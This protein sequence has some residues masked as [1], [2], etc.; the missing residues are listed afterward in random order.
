[1]EGDTNIYSKQKAKLVLL[2]LKH[3]L[4]PIPFYNL[5]K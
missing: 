5:F 3:C 2:K 4:S 1:M